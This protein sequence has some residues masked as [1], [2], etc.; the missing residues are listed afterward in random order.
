MDNKVIIWNLKHWMIFL[1]DWIQM[2]LTRTPAEKACFWI[3]PDQENNA[4]LTDIQAH[5]WEKDIFS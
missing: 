4:K 5:R 1:Q 3:N 2:M